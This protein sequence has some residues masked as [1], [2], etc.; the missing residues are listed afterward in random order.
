MLPIEEEG[1]ACEEKHQK[2]GAV[3]LPGG[4]E[5][6]KRH[7]RRAKKG[8]GRGGGEIEHPLEAGLES[9][10]ARNKVIRAWSSGLLPP[11]GRPLALRNACPRE[12]TT[13]PETA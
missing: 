11:R 3:L 10:E 4:S 2:T 5:G 8:K 13:T 12:Q 9:G 1:S 6:G 7:P